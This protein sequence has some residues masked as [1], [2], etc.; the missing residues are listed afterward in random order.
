MASDCDNTSSEGLYYKE[1]L[2]E[3]AQRYIEK[4]RGKKRVFDPSTERYVLY[5]RIST[6]SKDKQ[7]V[8][9]PDQIRSSKDLAER[10]GL[11]I[12]KVLREEES[13]KRSQK[14]DVFNEMMDGIRSGK[15]NSILTWHPDRLARNMKEAGEIIDMIDNGVIQNL[16][17][18]S[19]TFVKDANG[20][21]TLGIHFVL[22]KDFSEKLSVDTKR[23]IKSKVGLYLGRR[24]AGYKVVDD[25]FRPETNDYQILSKMWKMVLN[26]SALEE[27]AKYINHSGLKYKPNV[28]KKWV[29]GRLA[30]PFY[31]GIMCHGDN[32]IEIKEVD[33]G[34]TPMVDSKTFIAVRSKLDRHRAYQRTT[35]RTILFSKMVK[36]S[37][38]G[39]NMTPGKTESHTGK[40]YFRLIC[41]RQDCERN[42]RVP[43]SVRGEVL[44]DYIANLLADG[45]DV[46]KKV[47]DKMMESERARMKNEL[48]ELRKERSKIETEIK[49]NETKADGYARSMATTDRKREEDV[50]KR[51]DEIFGKMEEQKHR[52]GEV[53]V[54]ISEIDQNLNDGPIPYEKFSNLFENIGAILKKSDNRFLV[55]RLIRMVFLNLTVD[56]T[57]VVSHKLREPFASYSKLGSVSTGVEEGI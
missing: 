49:D 52:R 41:S 29:S 35:A 34:F 36:C 7:E 51:I 14:R 5:A 31:A 18:P 26:G 25:T 44:M 56:N 2:H 28:D 16:Q 32:K 22:A 40:R 10:Q 19:Y 9:I 46:N 23:G 1:R 38:C 33:D 20:I 12:A 24:K 4:R 43:K 15:Y 30:D 39:G 13:A 11:K 27:V 45:L 21:M 57:K 42:K 54:A 47:Y 53:D 6:K 8:S 37:Y 48:K 55:D 17:F 50:Q 3:Y